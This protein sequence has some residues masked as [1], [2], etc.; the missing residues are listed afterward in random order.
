VLKKVLI[1]SPFNNPSLYRGNIWNTNLQHGQQH[2]ASA[3]VLSEGG[4]GALEKA[5]FAEKKNTCE[6]RADLTPCLTPCLGRAGPDTG[7]G[8]VLEK[9]GRRAGD[10]GD[11]GVW[12]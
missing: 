1:H 12:V 6:S 7:S 10:F 9:A 8:A 2:P 11:E 4:K 3:S 5:G